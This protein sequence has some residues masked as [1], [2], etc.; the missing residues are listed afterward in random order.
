MRRKFVI[1]ASLGLVAA[2]WVLATAADDAAAPAQKKAVVGEAAPDFTLADAYGKKFSLSELKGKI[3]VLEW[4]NGAC[5]VSEKAHKT[6]SM[7][8][9]Y[10]KYVAKGIIWLGVDSTNGRTADQMRVQAVEQMLNYPVLSDPD[11]KAGKAFGAATTPHLFIID[12]EGKLVYSGSLDKQDEPTTNYVAA[13]IDDL[14]EGNAVK[15]SKTKPYG[16]GVKYAK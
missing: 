15:T 10:A 8:K 3:V 9:T 14:L 12:K 6:Q 7:Q 2:T 16:C 11:G 5:P 4:V 1:C 13:A